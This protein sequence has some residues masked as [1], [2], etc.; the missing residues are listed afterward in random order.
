M[1]DKLGYRAEVA[2]NGKGVLQAWRHGLTMFIYGVQMP[3]MD[4]LEA[5]KEIRQRWPEGGP[6]IIAIRPQR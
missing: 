4:G 2:A 6:K 1:L 3:E 5:T